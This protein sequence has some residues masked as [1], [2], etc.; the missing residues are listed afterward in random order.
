MP[1]PRVAPAHTVK[2][3]PATFEV[4]EGS[5]ARTEMIDGV[6]TFKVYATGDLVDFPDGEV[7]SRQP[8][9]RHLPDDY[10][11]AI[12]AQAAAEKAAEK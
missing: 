5:Y 4:T 7:G 6:A 8:N 2:G 12:R 10:V 3:K 9:L 11:K 1:A